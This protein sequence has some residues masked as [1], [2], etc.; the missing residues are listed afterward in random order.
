MTLRQ[1]ENLRTIKGFLLIIVGIP[2]FCAL[3][4]FLWFSTVTSVGRVNFLTVTHTLDDIVEAAEKVPLQPGQSMM[5]NLEGDTLVAHEFF[6]NVQ[7]LKTPSGS[8][9]VKVDR[10]GGHLGNQGYLYSEDTSINAAE[11][12]GYTEM[13]GYATSRM[14]LR[15]WSYD[16]T[17]D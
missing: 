2:L 16:S 6:G 8:I 15:W 11:A 9:L 5:G 4:F 14:S 12:F 10:G 13:E 7:V 3:C 17:E 1:K